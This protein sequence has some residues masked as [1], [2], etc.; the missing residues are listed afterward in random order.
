MTLALVWKEYRAQRAV[1]LFLTLIAVTA[2]TSLRPLLA[3][4]TGRE[5]MLL[6]IVLA[7]AWGY[8]MVC[9]ALLLGLERE[10]DTQTFLDMLPGSRRRLWRGKLV[11]GVGLVLLQSAAL[12]GLTLVVGLRDQ[13]GEVAAALLTL[14]CVGL[15]GLAWGLLAGTFAPNVLQAV[16]LA[17]VGQLAASAVA[18]PLVV[19]PV[20][21]LR[22]FLEQAPNAGFAWPELLAG[23]ALLTGTALVGSRLVFARD[24]RLRMRAGR[25]DPANEKAG[26][27]WGVLCWLAW[28]QARGLAYVVAVVATLAGVLTATLNVLLWPALGALIGIVCGTTVFADEQDGGA[29]RFLGDQRYSLTRI[30]IVKTGVRALITAGAVLLM[31]LAVVL[32]TFLTRLDLDRELATTQQFPLFPRFF[33]GAMLLAAGGPVLF[34]TLWAA[35]GFAIGQFCGLICRRPLLAL[36]IALAVGMPAV[37]LWLP[38]LEMG[39]L[40]VW[41]VAIVPVLLLIATWRLMP[42]WAAGRL[43]AGRTVATVAAT[44]GAALVGTAACLGYR[45][46]EI[47]PAAD[48]PDLEGFVAGLPTPEENEGA[49][50]IRAALVRMQNVQQAVREAT[51]PPVDVPPPSARD[52]EPSVRERLGNVVVDR[53]WPANDPELSALVDRLFADDWPRDLAAAVDLPPGVLLDPRVLTLDSALPELEAASEAGR[54][55]AVR[56]LQRQAA[57]DPAEFVRALHTIL[58]LTRTLRDR[59]LL[60]GVLVS[61]RMEEHSL[62]ALERWLER[63]DGQPE[64]LRKVLADL[65]QHESAGVA[66]AEAVRRVELLVALN[67]VD[68]PEAFLALGD[69]P[70]VGSARRSEANLLAFALRMPWER[71]RVLRLLD[72]LYS[73]DR[74]HAL[75]AREMA[76]LAF[77]HLGSLTDILS[78][79]SRLAVQQARVRTRLLFVALRLYEAE[80]GQLPAS[81][82]ALVPQYLPAVPADP[83]DGAPFRY[84]V[85]RGE[86]LDWPAAEFGMEAYHRSPREVPKGQGI[87]WCVGPDGRDDGGKRQADWPRDPQVSETDLIFL[88]PPRL[89]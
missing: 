86:R 47:P 57:S 5:E 83:F 73:A 3:S 42:A 17:G 80:H 40:H 78:R 25:I 31:L 1:W 77:R 82:D 61:W 11:V 51:R 14:P 52:R 16:V 46:A 10:D 72:Q 60:I 70:A 49:R 12:A 50:L 75:A 34:V 81:L 69:V 41:Q 67:T 59:P 71:A 35:V 66:D 65:R 68:D 22:T 30:W 38:S 27:G 62:T 28:Q 26:A 32:L 29:Y 45:V 2:L 7:V 33:P 19:L 24:D 43:G 63:L 44:I 9:G 4:G 87:L 20:G 58:P 54:L 8:G 39:G 89:R 13:H 76:P 21:A 64:L 79:N 56:G 18:L 85:S 48:A 74:Q 88:V 23:T 15:L 55:L 36:V 53:G 6:G 37:A 84:R